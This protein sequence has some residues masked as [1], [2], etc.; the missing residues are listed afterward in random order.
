MFRPQITVVDC[1]IRDGGLMNNS[2]FD[3]D[4]VKAVYH[5]VCAA[6]MGAPAASVTAPCSHVSGRS[7]RNS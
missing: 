4:F 3:L 5:A 6:G 1:T 2:N 7:H